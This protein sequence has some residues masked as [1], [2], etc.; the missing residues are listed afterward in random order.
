MQIKNLTK[1]ENNV[2]LTIVAD[3]VTQGVASN[4][5]T[6]EGPDDDSSGIETCRP[7]RINNILMNVVFD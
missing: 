3:K 7:S 4:G 6:V 5:N 2:T 1:D